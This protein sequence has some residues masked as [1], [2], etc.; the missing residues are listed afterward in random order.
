MKKW[1]FIIFKYNEYY[2]TRPC[3]R[4]VIECATII[5][6]VIIKNSDKINSSD[7][8]D[9]VIQASHAE[10][11]DSLPDTQSK[12]DLEILS[13][14]NSLSDSLVEMCKNHDKSSTSPS[15]FELHCNE[16]LLSSSDKKEDD[17]MCFFS[18]DSDT[19]DSLVLQCM[20]FYVISLIIV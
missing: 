9:I 17:S 6:D 14:N 4:H 7:E 19:P 8:S 15:L 12:E 13:Q 18:D 1:K 5:E 20:F 11:G 16:T 2:K 3:L 10:I